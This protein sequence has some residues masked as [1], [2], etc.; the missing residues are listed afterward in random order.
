MVVPLP[1]GTADPH[2][3]LSRIAAETA[4][5][6][7]TARP[8]LG[9]VFR[10]RPVS[11]VLLKRIIRRRINLTSADIPG[12]PQPLYFAGARLRELFPLLNLIG[13]VTLGVAAI[14]YA[15]QFNAMVVA[16]AVGYPDL[17]VFAAGMAEELAVLGQPDLRLA[18]TANP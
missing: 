2:E 6:K 10:S 11:A 15:G 17:E 13:N 7:A 12:P 5:R 9:S 4:R 14:S 3:R 1:I 16:D 8:S 18:A